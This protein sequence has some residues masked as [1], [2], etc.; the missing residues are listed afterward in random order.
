MSA[1]KFVAYVWIIQD[2]ES[3]IAKCGGHFEISSTAWLLLCRKKDSPCSLLAQTV[4]YFEPDR[5]VGG[6]G[7]EHL[8]ANPELRQ[9]F[10]GQLRQLSRSCNLPAWKKTFYALTTFGIST[11]HFRL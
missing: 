3:S 10:S 7:F 4:S 2:A 9:K 1:C 6:K 5:I 8:L 11:S